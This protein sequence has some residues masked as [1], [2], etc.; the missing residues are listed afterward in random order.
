MRKIFRGCIILLAVMT[1]CSK[2]L[3]EDQN[4]TV[5]ESNGDIGITP[6][7]HVLGH[8]EQRDFHKG[9]TDFGK[10]ECVFELNGKAYVYG[11]GGLY[12][13]M[14]LWEYNDNTVT[15]TRK[16]D[17]PAPNREGVRAA[18]SINGKG[19]LL[20]GA[21][22]FT[23]T[24]YKEVWEYNPVSNQWTR[25]AD[26]PGPGRHRAVSFAIN[27]KG[28]YGLGGQFSQVYTDFYEYNPVTDTWTQKANFPAAGRIDAF[29]FAASGKGYVGTGHYYTYAQ[30]LHNYLKDVW[31][32]NP[33][34]NA[35]TQ[36]DNY[37]GGPR[38]GCASFTIDNHGH[39]GTGYDPINDNYK[40]DFY[41]YYTSNV[42]NY[43]WDYGGYARTDAIGFA[44]NGYGFIGFGET[45]S[46]DG[47]RALW[48]FE[49]YD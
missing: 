25:K 28:Y 9:S 23:G 43:R 22:Q 39:V 32:Y 24:F 37:P 49:A 2:D 13:P 6:Q 31:E 26:L 27:G 4:S 33:A 17:F 30:T 10:A 11:W 16:A 42:W 35:W 36:K 34:T 44:L 46:G 38:I 47:E 48:R 7:I 19:Y 29:S 14:E 45:E 40:K 15:W 21:L 12:N 3:K 18:F 20:C 8:W 5:K 1:G 41:A